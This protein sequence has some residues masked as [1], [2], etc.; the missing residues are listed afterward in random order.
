MQIKRT[1]QPMSNSNFA[2]DRKAGQSIL[3]PLEMRLKNW[4]VP[5]IPLSIETYHLTFTTILWSA[6]VL[7]FGWLAASAIFT[8]WSLV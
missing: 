1:D 8:A 2:G 7:L 3:T 4:M 6:G 5:K